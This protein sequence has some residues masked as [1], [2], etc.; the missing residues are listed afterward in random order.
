MGVIYKITNKINNKIYIGKTIVSEPVRWQQHIWHAYNNPE[1]DCIKLCNAIKKYG[2]ENF[3]RD[4]IEECSDDKL[5]KEREIYWIKYFNSTNDN[6]GYNISN[7][8]DGYYKY[9]DEDILKLYKK[10]GTIAETAR[11]L[12]AD[13]STI[14]KRLQGLGINTY[15]TNILQINFKKEIVGKYESLA[16]AKRITNLNLPQSIN[17][18]TS[19]YIS[20]N[21]IWIYEKDYNILNLDEI[22]NHYKKYCHKKIEQYDLNC[23]Y[24]TTYN[25]SAEASK[26]TKI[27]ISSIKACA[28]GKQ[29]TAGNF[30]W[31]YEDNILS[32][33][34]QYNKYLLSPSCCEIDEIDENGNIIAT[35]KSAAQLER[36]MNW[37]Y[38]CVKK[39]CDGKQKATHGRRF[40]YHNKDKIRLLNQNRADNY[41]IKQKTRRN[42]K[43]E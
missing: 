4:I 14:S 42:S 32:L 19:N 25:S 17:Y 30:I 5:L 2:K 1:N 6:I 13:K 12:K 35:Y 26:N 33:E 16:E 31:H 9:S 10:Y 7:G 11:I 27:N 34:E 8:G 39:V 43:F 37:S 24:I 20:N 28:A 36:Q 23:N 18:K 38:N 29:V 15:N 41:G 40:E 21:Y 3:Q 22:I